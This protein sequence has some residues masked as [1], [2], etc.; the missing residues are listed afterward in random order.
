MS[1]SA[2]PTTAETTAAARN[3]LIEPAKHTNRR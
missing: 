1:A 2:R 3:L